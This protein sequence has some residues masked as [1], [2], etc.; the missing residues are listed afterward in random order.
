MSDTALQNNISVFGLQHT[1]KAWSPFLY[2]RYPGKRIYETE[3]DCCHNNDWA[4]AVIE[5][6]LLATFLNT[7]TAQYSEW[8]MVL[9]QSG[10]SGWNWKQASM[11]TVDTTAKT[12]TYNPAFYAVKHWTHYIRRNARRIKSVN[13]DPAHKGSVSAY[14]NPNGDIVLLVGN[15]AAAVDTLSVKLGSKAFKAVLPATSMN[16]FVIS[17]SVSISNSAPA[18]KALS[19]VLGLRMKN[20]TLTFS[21]SPKARLQGISFTLCDLRGRVVWSG[22]RNAADLNPGAVHSIAVKSGQRRIPDG[23]YLLSMT[24]NSAGVTTRFEKRISSGF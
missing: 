24:V 3:T 19:P 4:G 14:R 17:Q 20:S 5:F 2:S 8:N 23:C 18:N 15:E 22:S 21:V 12:I 13:S 7:G 6:N 16:T 9:D 1:K 10:L 11:I